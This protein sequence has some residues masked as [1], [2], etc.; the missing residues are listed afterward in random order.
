MW[1]MGQL[2]K[3][4]ASMVDITETPEGVI[5]TRKGMPNQRKRIPWTSILCA[6]EAVEGDEDA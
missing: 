5:I 2:G 4:S 3:V 6:E 1:N